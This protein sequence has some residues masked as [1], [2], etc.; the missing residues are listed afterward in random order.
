[1]IYVNSV[2]NYNSIDSNSISLSK[3]PA[4][5]IPKDNLSLDMTRYFQIFTIMNFG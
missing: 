2:T 5:T 1:M 3:A 4:P